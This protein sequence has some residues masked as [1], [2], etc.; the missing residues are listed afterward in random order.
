MEQA[1]DW[2]QGP[3]ARDERDRHN[4]TG[5]TDFVCPLCRSTGYEAIPCYRGADLLLY[6]CQGCTLTFT[7]PRRFAKQPG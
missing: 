7:N 1:S 3:G 4:S 2:R 6:K 5:E